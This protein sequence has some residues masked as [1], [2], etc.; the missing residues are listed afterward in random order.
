MKD[1]H[2]IFG[3]MASFGKKEYSITDLLHLSKPFNI[4]ENSLRTNLSRMKNNTV[5]TSRKEGKTVYYSFYKKGKKMSLIAELSFNPPNWDNWNNEWLGVLFTID[6][7]NKEKRYQ[8]RKRLIVYRFAPQ[9]P[10]VW[11]RPLNRIENE[12]Y[13]FEKILNNENS[14]LIRFNYSETITTKEVQNL[15]KIRSINKEYE[16]GIRII[17]KEQK[18][19]DNLNPELALIQKMEIGNALIELIFKDPLLPPEFLP[20]DWKGNQLRK[21]YFALDKILT[22]ISKPYW[23]KIFN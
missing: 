5:L 14:K 13:N 11:M 16:N 8:M 10:G 12:K 6:E 18:K 9:Y 2:L 17:E 19:I 23:K 3:L 1:S 15:W 22:E 20:E 4:T 7:N 21:E